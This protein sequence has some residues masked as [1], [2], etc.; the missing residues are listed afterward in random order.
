MYLQE[1]GRAGRDGKQSIAILYNISGQYHVDDLM[2]QYLKNKTKC[3]R[4]I[5]LQHFYQNKPSIS[6]CTVFML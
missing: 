5:L 1:T 2:K 3:R 4:E 6:M